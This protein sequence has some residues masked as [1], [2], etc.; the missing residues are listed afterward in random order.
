[1]LFLNARKRKFREKVAKAKEKKRKVL[2][3]ARGAL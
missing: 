3:E 2:G 1:M